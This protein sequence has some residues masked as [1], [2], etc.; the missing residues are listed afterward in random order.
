MESLVVEKRFSVKDEA[1]YRRLILPEEDRAECTALQL[2]RSY[3]WFRSENVVCIEHY[4]QPT[5]A[6]P[7]P[8][9]K[10]S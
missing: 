1:F 10:V 7:A 8:R 9:L 6:K 4:R 3:R 5:G 2:K